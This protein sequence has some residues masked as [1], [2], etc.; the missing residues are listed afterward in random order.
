MRYYLQDLFT[1]TRD[2]DP[3][4][5]FM[6]LNDLE[7]ELVDPETKFTPEAKIEYADCLLRCLDDEFAEVRSQALKCFETLTPR[8][9]NYVATVLKSLSTKK[10]EKISITSSIYTMAIHNILKNLIPN[11]PTA[12]EIV[13]SLLVYLLQDENGFFTIIDCIEVLT[14]LLEYLGR[15]FN[16]S[17][18]SGTAEAL[19]KSS[20]K[21]DAII[22]KKSVSCLALL[23][24][25]ISSTSQMSEILD[26]TFTFYDVCP[27]YKNQEVLL[28]IIS[29]LIKYNPSMMSELYD[30]I[31]PAI[32]DGLRMKTISEP[33]E[34]F[35]LQQ[36]I[37][38][39]RS[40]ALNCLSASFANIPLYIMEEYADETLQLCSKFIPYDPYSENLD[41][42]NDGDNISVDEGS[43]YYSEDD[44]FEG[45][46][47]DE[48]DSGISWILRKDAAVL[49]SSLLERLP[50]RL[51]SIYR[52]VFGDLI[53]QLQDSKSAV[54]TESL[55]TIIKLFRYSSKEGPYF[56]LRSL[57][58]LR[59]RAGGSRGSDVSMLSEEDPFA[60]LVSKS[61]WI[62]ENFEKLL[63]S[64]NAG[65][66]PILYK[67][68]SEL[69]NATEGLESPWIQTFVLKLDGLR[70]GPPTFELV[71]FYSSLLSKNSLQSFASGFETVIDNIFLCLKSS[72]HE[73]VME[74]LV[75]VNAILSKDIP[76]DSPSPE[77]LSLFAG[78]LD[79]LLIE[80]T[81]NKNYSTEIR[82]IA[83]IALSNLVLN[84]PL[85]AQKMSRSVD[86]FADMITLEFLVSTD[87]ECIELLAGSHV[88]VSQISISWT[89][90]VLRSLIEYIS[91]SE[92]CT[93]ALSA[94]YSLVSAGLLGDSE[95]KLLLE[96]LNSLC[97]SRRLS[98]KN[99]ITNAKIMTNILN[100]TPVEFSK[101]LVHDLI[102]FSKNSQID[103]SVLTALTKS[104]LNHTEP[105]RLI[106]TV[107][108]DNKRTDPNVSKLLAV[109]SVAAGHLDSIDKILDD[110]KGG[111]DILFSLVFLEQVSK[112]VDL[113]SN[114][115][116]FFG[117][118]DSADEE[119]KNAAVQAAS[120][121]IAARPDKYMPELLQAISS[122]TV[123]KMQLLR[124]LS[125][126]LENIHL[127]VEDSQKVFAVVVSAE[128]SSGSENSVNQ[129]TLSAAECLAR[130]ALDNSDMVNDFCDIL[131]GD[132]SQNL[133]T[134][135]SSAVKFLL[136]DDGFLADDVYLLSRYLEAA[137]ADDF[138]F[139]SNLILKR[140]GVANLILFVYKRPSIALPLVSKL[141]PRILEDELGQKKEYVKVVRIGPFKH[142]LD[143]AL[144]FRKE[145]YELIYS[146]LTTLESDPNLAVLFTVDWTG[147]L[148]RIV[149]KSFKDDPTIIFLCLL[150]IL[151][152]VNLRPD[153]FSGNDLLADFIQSCNKKLN[154]KLRDE[155]PKQDIEKHNDTVRAILRCCKKVD[156]LIDKGT[157]KLDG[158]V[159]SEWRSYISSIRA[160]YPIFDSEE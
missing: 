30:R 103:G 113:N 128:E 140:N 72:N 127:S 27:N 57:R 145:L 95:K 18:L 101:P 142:K 78:T 33:N 40:A 75:L 32:V 86:I 110:L 10:P 130:I 61:D 116:P 76:R 125:L 4:L 81:S 129:D 25:Y 138:L 17:Q 46:D 67:F 100:S 9:G 13:K 107:L 114:L 111:R 15:Y 131:A 29:A 157:V 39:V 98:T 119:I 96:T 55:K 36:E 88:V 14:D 74:A 151:K 6:A 48:Y 159:L 3:D 89:T 71:R 11:D 150:I 146:T 92:L 153:I 102:K 120:E 77:L 12:K 22:A 115:A 155:A 152:I 37:D 21:A 149:D 64:A 50:T 45:E 79:D 108:E 147:L 42:E 26:S 41:D 112:S 104:I 51:P 68:V 52:S 109:I 31:H 16:Q 148:K 56:S 20:F 1:Q 134:S 49:V 66:L 35:D 70:D 135:V 83:L 132:H 34:D 2:T 65:K 62:C 139:S 80:K 143:D 85:D 123:D 5:R 73:L 60:I 144:D 154:R 97:A 58:T 158:D 69:S 63:V 7:K 23:S 94:T 93:Q 160:K 8:L 136:D 137:A 43:D 82:R 122:H 118:F 84:V 54:V 99:S 28:S 91:N 156:S 24:R 121:I 117:Y 90:S 47:E 141:L 105:S 19:I 38:E 87:L 44:E 106:D 133:K 124:C 59:D 53:P 126:V